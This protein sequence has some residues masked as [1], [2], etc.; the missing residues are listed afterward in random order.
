MEISERIATRKERIV[1]LWDELANKIEARGI[2]VQERLE[3]LRLLRGD[4]PDRE[5][6][7]DRRERLLGDVKEAARRIEE[8][9]R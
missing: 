7:A 6:L 4:A 9:L 2:R 3:L 1:S 8:A 5:S